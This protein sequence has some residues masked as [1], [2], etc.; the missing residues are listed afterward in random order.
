MQ[1]VAGVG[2]EAAAGGSI[3]IQ[4]TKDDI[5][6]DKADQDRKVKFID[7]CKEFTKYCSMY[8]FDVRTALNKEGNKYYNT[9]RADQPVCTKLDINNKGP[10]GASSS[11][12]VQAPSSRKPRATEGTTRNAFSCLFL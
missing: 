3:H 1:T 11:T 10:V 4:S 2:T 5:A 12:G 6:Q 7:M 8:S 9:C